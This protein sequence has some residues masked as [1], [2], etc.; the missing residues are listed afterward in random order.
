MPEINAA[1]TIRAG[2]SWAGTAHA[3]AST[4]AFASLHNTGVGFFP[5]NMQSATGAYAVQVAIPSYAVGDASYLVSLGYLRAGTGFDWAVA[6]GFG[7]IVVARFDSSNAAG[8]EIDF[9]QA[10]TA[11]TRTTIVFEWNAE[12]WTVYALEAA[13]SATDSAATIY[14]DDKDID[15]FV[16]HANR[17]QSSELGL[18]ALGA[19]TGVFIQAAWFSAPLDTATRAKLKDTKL[20]TAS[21]LDTVSLNYTELHCTDVVD[22]GGGVVV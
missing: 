20:W 9:S 16:L 1:G 15:A 7:T 3:S 6:Y 18:L 12:K 2:F 5:A 21:V 17:A 19:L 22:N 13:T 11:N 4:F 14:S 10:I 8:S